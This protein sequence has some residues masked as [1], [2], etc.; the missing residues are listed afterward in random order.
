[1]MEL[2]D[3][4][5]VDRCRILRSS[6]KRGALLELVD[7]MASNGPVSDG[8]RL[9][10]L[11]FSRETSMST[12]IG[13]GIAVPHARLERL[14]SAAVALGVSPSGI[15]NYDSLDDEP[16]R[17]VVMIVTAAGQPEKYSNLLA[18]AVSILK[19]EPVRADLTLAS[20]PAQIYS[21]VRKAALE[22]ND[23]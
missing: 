15:A 17:L 23:S 1:M 16:V 20:A 8:E 11:I 18:E 5:S 21:I 3:H 19:R 7:L 9:Q 2:L 4:I 13:L 22:E 10:Q 6:Y 14:R 12:G